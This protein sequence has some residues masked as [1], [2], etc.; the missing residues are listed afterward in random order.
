MRTTVTTS[1]VR[2]A[3]QGMT[4]IDVIVGSALL[5]IVF[6]SIIFGFR[7]SVA[8]ISKTRGEQ[9]AVS[10]IS[11]Q[12]ERI[13]ALPYDS[14]G[15]MLGIPSGTIPQQET[16]VLNG[17][18][19][20]KQVLIQYVDDPKDGLDADDEN[21]I[22]ADYKR[23]RVEVSWTNRGQNYEKVLIT[24]IVPKG[25]ETTAGGGTIRISV[26]DALVQPVSGASVRVINTTTNPAIDVTTG[27]NTNGIVLF[28]GAPA[29]AG[30]QISVTKSGYSSAQTYTADVANPNPN[31]GHISVLETQTSSISF[32]IDKVS[33]MDVYTH[34]P[35]VP[36][37]VA[38]TFDDAT[39]ISESSNTL[40]F[41]GTV[42][43]A[44]GATGFESSGTLYSTQIPPATP[45]A[46]WTEL[47]W[48]D[49]QPANTAITYQLY[50]SDINSVRQI[51]PD[52]ALAGNSTG[53][54]SSPVALDTINPALYPNLIV[55][56]TL[57]T[58]DELVTPSIADW[59]VAYTTG[60]TLVPNV[61]FSLRGA[62]IIGT[63]TD[64]QP[65]YKYDTSLVTD[66]T[67]HK[68]ASPL[69][70]DMYS[71]NI[72]GAVTG[73]DISESCSP[74]PVVLNPNITQI[75]DLTL[76]THTT[77]SLH[78]VVTDTAGAALSSASV[79]LTRPGYD[80]TQSSSACGQTFFSG[81]TND[82]YT[83]EVSHAGYTTDTQLLSI[84]G[85]QTVT[86]VLNP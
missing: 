29:S 23:A 58:S 76:M 38:D 13:R 20:T 8:L 9:G 42:I 69:E 54:T 5:L 37:T 57:T 77:N 52:S 74:S 71:I 12:L 85:T 44:T 16:M 86:V 72:N 4:F 66:A 27:S 17:I 79:R 1:R 68:I 62:K 40:V 28:S 2:S 53:F 56:G 61:A 82:D 6:G 83:L 31:P 70:W 15:T 11:A 49:T 25:I 34:E 7:F 35:V 14:V 45:V 78:V 24:T 32:A 26:F 64:A 67:G 41:G 10:L 51:V 63:D 84:S 48:N 36:A 46:G 55:R 43:L 59:S 50:Y 75:V 60:P 65:I 47:S 21:G 81:I 30:Y 22:T 39:G 19:Y 73:Y 3:A 33:T 80:T 18:T